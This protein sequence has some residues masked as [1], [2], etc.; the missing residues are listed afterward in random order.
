MSTPTT[1][2][3]PSEAA[4]LIKDCSERSGIA[5]EH[6]FDAVCRQ[7][8]AFALMDDPDVQAGDIGRIFSMTDESSRLVF[9][10]NKLEATLGGKQHTA[11]SIVKKFLDCHSSACTDILSFIG[12]SDF[13]SARG[14]LHDIIGIS[15]NLCCFRL[16]EASEKLRLECRAEKVLSQ[17]GFSGTW[18]VTVFILSLYTELFNKPDP[19]S[20]RDVP[21]SKVLQSFIDLCK[22]FDIQAADC[23]EQ[24]R[25]QFRAAFSENTFREIEAAVSRYDMLWIAENISSESCD[26]VT[27]IR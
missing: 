15:G 20:D 17:N 27:D 19:A 2:I 4:K 24:H 18:D 12:E 16:L 26:A 3:T 1:P 21:F 13:V 25:S 5:T 8:S 11:V 23:F 9:D 22:D 14:V 7:P 6:A 10:R